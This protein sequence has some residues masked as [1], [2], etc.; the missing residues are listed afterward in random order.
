MGPVFD[1][2][3]GSVVGCLME[4]ICQCLQEPT[5]SSPVAHSWVETQCSEDT[6]WGLLW[7]GVRKDVW[8]LGW[9]EG[10]GG[11]RKWGAAPDRVL[12]GSRASSVVRHPM[13]L[14]SKGRTS[15]SRSCKWRGSRGSS[16][17]DGDVRSLLW[18]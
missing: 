1:L 7:E 9:C 3:R 4:P 2:G 16:S 17:Q 8:D 5:P 14:L 6:P 15:P 13:H 11:V 10:I 12:S 18:L